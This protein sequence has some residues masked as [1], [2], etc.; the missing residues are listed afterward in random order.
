[1]KIKL[2]CIAVLLMSGSVAVNAQFGN[3]LDKA[4]G[5]T[6]P[7]TTQQPSND[8]Q[9]APQTRSEEGTQARPGGYKDSEFLL[10]GANGLA[11]QGLTKMRACVVG[12]SDQ[13]TAPPMS[14]L[15]VSWM[16]HIDENAALRLYEVKDCQVIAYQIR[17]GAATKYTSIDSLTESAQ[18]KSIYRVE[19]GKLVLARAV[20]ASEFYIVVVPDHSKPGLKLADLRMCGYPDTIKLFVRRVTHG[21]N[22]HDQKQKLYVFEQY[23]NYPGPMQT[24]SV[25]FDAAEFGQLNTQG[26]FKGLV[27]YKLINDELVPSK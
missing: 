2:L 23:K 8:N 14:E 7:N 4:K 17:E 6:K 18:G 22:C 27:I 10:I 20:G 16:N 19:S 9:A 21:S 11:G 25:I 15:F 3:I 26:K 12:G 13:R 1:M 5:K 24:S